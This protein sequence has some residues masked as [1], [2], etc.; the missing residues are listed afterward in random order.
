[1]G[2]VKA[3]YL[4]TSSIDDVINRQVI[5]WTGIQ[6]SAVEFSPSQTAY[7]GSGAYPASYLIDTGVF[8]RIETQW[9]TIRPLTSI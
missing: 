5:E 8:L 9:T 2:L 1:M 6:I 4:L 7:T 3:C